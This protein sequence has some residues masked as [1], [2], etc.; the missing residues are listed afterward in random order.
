MDVQRLA[1][2]GAFAM[3]F[4]FLFVVV[5][6]PDFLY[7][8]IGLR[9]PSRTPAGPATTG[10]HPASGYLHRRSRSVSALRF[11]HSVEGW[12]A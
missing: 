6:G 10:N 2:L 5:I 11:L 4:L 12:T 8:A 1:G 3:V 7:P 9:R